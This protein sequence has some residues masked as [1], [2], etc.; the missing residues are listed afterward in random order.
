MVVPVTG[1]VTQ[2]VPTTPAFVRGQRQ[3]HT[4]YE[5]G[6]SGPNHDLLDR[7]GGEFAAGYRYEWAEYIAPLMPPTDDDDD[8]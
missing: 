5:R 7:V 1:Q 4:D 8:D 6:S 2:V 3:A